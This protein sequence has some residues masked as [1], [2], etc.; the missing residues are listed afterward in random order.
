M[1]N[2]LDQ[3]GFTLIELMT[4][5]VIVMIISLVS[6]PTYTNMMAHQRLNSAARTLLADIR[7]TREQAIKEGWQYGILFN[8]SQQYQVIKST[9]PTFIQAVAAGGTVFNVVVTRNFTSSN[10]GYSQIT[11]TVPVNMPVFQRS[12]MVSSWNSGTANYSSTT[13]P[14]QIQLTNSNGDS[15]IVCIDAMGYSHI[16][17]PTG[18]C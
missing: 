1:T 7:G 8:S 12:G 14:G 18:N 4:V 2:K 3:K 13:A 17:N 11:M 6:F 10:L 15:K 9:L 5:I 16:I